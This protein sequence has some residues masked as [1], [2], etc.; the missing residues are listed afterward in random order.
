MPADVPTLIPGAP[1]PEAAFLNLAAIWA[2][3][4]ATKRRADL[5]SLSGPAAEAARTAIA[6]KSLG[7]KAGLGGVLSLEES[8]GGGLK[9]IKLPG[10]ELTLNPSGTDVHGRATVAAEEWHAFAA[11]F[12]DLA[13]PGAPRRRPVGVSR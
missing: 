1:I 6:A 5:A 8:T 13:L 9:G 12:L 4:E 7:F 11:Q 10:L 2:S 3:G